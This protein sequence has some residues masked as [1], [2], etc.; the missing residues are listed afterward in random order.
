VG[1]FVTGAALLVVAGLLVVPEIAAL[2]GLQG[3]IEIQHVA[4]LLAGLG[5][6]IIFTSVVIV[7]PA[8]RRDRVGVAAGSAITVAGAVLFWNVYPQR[9]AGAQNSLAFEVAI[10]Y[11]VGGCLAL[12]FVF[13]AIA[14]FKLRNNPAGKVSLEIRKEGETRTIEVTRSE[15]Q[16]YRQLAGDGGTAAILSEL[17][18]EHDGS[19]ETEPT[20]ETANR[21]QP[22]T[23]R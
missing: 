14:N 8:S 16:R 4:G 3:K 11:F 9:W 20:D 19:S 6:P 7:L 18:V 23:R 15:L 13:A 17:D 21:R 2:A 5:V 12:W 1:V 22:A 10:V